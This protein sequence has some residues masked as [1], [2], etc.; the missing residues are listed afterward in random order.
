MAAKSFR[1]RRGLKIIFLLPESGD[2]A[3]VFEDDKAERQVAP[4]EGR[5]GAGKPRVHAGAREQG[6]D[7]AWPVHLQDGRALAF[8]RQKVAQPCLGG[9]FAIPDFA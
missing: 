1:A 9:E 7:F 2:W 5:E 8:G 4:V 6:V 3:A